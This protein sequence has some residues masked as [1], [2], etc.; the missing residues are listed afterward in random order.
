MVGYFRS[1]FR[2]RLKRTPSFAWSGL[3]CAVADLPAPQ[4]LEDVRPAYA[5][6]L[7]DEDVAD[8]KGIERD[9]AAPQL[10]RR[11]RHTLITD[12]LGEMEHWACFHLEETRL[13]GSREAHSQLRPSILSQQTGGP[14]TTPG[15]MKVLTGST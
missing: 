10:R 5:V 9:L 3:V 15:D 6:E 14:K 7:V 4:L 13:T 1:L 11:E 2:G 8:L 12:A